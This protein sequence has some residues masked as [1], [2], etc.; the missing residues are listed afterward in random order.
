[1]KRLNIGG[2]ISPS[3]KGATN[4]SRSSGSKT[5]AS[6]GTTQVIDG[7]VIWSPIN[8]TTISAKFLKVTKG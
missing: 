8:K 2:I 3:V 6:S 5:S 4:K 7:N 1:M